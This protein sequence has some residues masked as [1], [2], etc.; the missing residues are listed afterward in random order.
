MLQGMMLD[1]YKPGPPPH[2]SPT[3]TRDC[4]RMRNAIIW[5]WPKNRFNFL[6]D[7][8]TPVTV[9]LLCYFRGTRCQPSGQHCIDLTWVH[10]VL[11]NTRAQVL[12]HRAWSCPQ[13]ARINLRTDNPVLIKF[14]VAEF[15]EKLSNHFILYLYTII[16]TATLHETISTSLSLYEIPVKIVKWIDTFSVSGYTWKTIYVNGV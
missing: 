2:S 15:Y 14:N 8:W 9:K 6:P 13:H 11:K 7:K 12:W 10:T 16:L 3:L 4:A 1:Q 5:P